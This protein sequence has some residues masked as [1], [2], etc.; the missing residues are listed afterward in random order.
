VPAC[1]PCKCAGKRVQRAQPHAARHATDARS[2]RKRAQQARGA[3]MM[4]SSRW[5][6]EGARPAVEQVTLDFAC[7][8]VADLKTELKALGLS[9]A[10]LKSVLVARLKEA[11]VGGGGGGGGGGE[12][13][14]NPDTIAPARNTAKAAKTPAPSPKKM[15]LHRY[16]FDLLTFIFI[17][18]YGGY[19]VALVWAIVWAYF[20][21]SE[22]GP[23]AGGRR[24]Q[25]DRRSSRS[26]A[27]VALATPTPQ[28][29]QDSV[30][31]S[32]AQAVGATNLF[33][34]P[35]QRDLD[36][37]E[38]LKQDKGKQFGQVF[39]TRYYEI[40]Y[41]L[42]NNAGLK[43]SMETV[44][45]VLGKGTFGQVEKACHLSTGK[46]V[47]VK[48]IRLLSERESSGFRRTPLC[49]VEDEMRVHQDLI[50]PNVVR[51]YGGF[52]EESR[53]YMILE[54]VPGNEDLQVFLCAMKK[55][56]IEEATT[57]GMFR[58]LIDGVAYL[59]DNGVVHRDLKPENIMV[60]KRSDSVPLLKIAD[61]GE[62]E[63]VGTDNSMCKT[64]KGTLQT[65]APEVSLLNEH[66]MG[67]RSK[68]GIDGKKADLWSLGMILHVM[69]VLE[70]PSFADVQ[71]DFDV[72]KMTKLANQAMTE[73]QENKKSVR[74]PDLF[75]TKV[76]DE[77]KRS[78]AK[79]EWTD[80]DKVKKLVK[81]LLKPA[82]AYRWDL[83]RVK[84]CSWLSWLDEK[85]KQEDDT[86]TD[87]N[88][89]D[90]VE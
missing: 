9:D 25:E 24:D 37:A 48:V 62:A 4:L 55:E 16:H 21:T 54:L 72:A 66:S 47:A 87:A 73:E 26:S 40:P 35:K 50:H 5:V 86:D 69:V 1:S 31:S 38:R 13:S 30:I 71:R 17:T 77:Q 76:W 32:V 60:C 23:P 20:W 18:T 41:K 83:E 79:Y 82:V 65:M 89:I 43:I 74:F 52:K 88:E 49:K 7:V 44:E 68:T 42:A 36:L 3:P 85:Q 63:K 27:E 56:N 70:Y 46:E 15:E 53:Y 2:A 61:L 34:T 81:G 57:K 33:D 19:P 75:D 58:Q 51:L 11:L 22:C 59:H 90:Y 10:G 45:V 29:V 67:T 14:D 6:A 64:R 28:A 12:G 8:Q 80:L 84:K 78:K 39:S